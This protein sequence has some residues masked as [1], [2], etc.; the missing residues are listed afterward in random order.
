MPEPFLSAIVSVGGGARGFVVQ[1]RR[2]RR[3]VITARHCLRMMPRSS[4]IGAFVGELVHSDHEPLAR[5]DGGPGPWLLPK[6]RITRHQEAEFRRGAIAL[7]PILIHDTQDIAV[8][9]VPGD[10]TEAYDAFVGSREALVLGP[11]PRT[12]ELFH[13]K[14]LSLDGAWFDCEAVWHTEHYPVVYIKEFAKPLL[15]GMSG[16]PIIDDNGRAFG[17]V[18]KVGLLEGEAVCLVRCLP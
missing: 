17:V 13:A 15:K 2:E 5:Y 9:G 11:P 16:S 1:P 12:T 4:F 18:F 3:Y 8:L 7:Q 10:D 6:Q 14:L